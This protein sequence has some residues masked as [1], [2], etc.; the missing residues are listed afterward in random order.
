MPFK[1]GQIANPAGRPIGS[2][3]KF[4]FNVSEILRDLKYIDEKG[5]SKVGFNPFEQ[6]AKL[7]IYS[8]S[9]KVKCEASSELA[10][11]V[12]PKLKHIEHA[13]DAESPFTITLNFG[14][15]INND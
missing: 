1:K 13:S 2:G 15:K 5:E 6:L 14:H 12:A 3:T 4:R 7:A 10:S 11:Y 8:K 9:D